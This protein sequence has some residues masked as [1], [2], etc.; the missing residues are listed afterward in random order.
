MTIRVNVDTA[1][2]SS[3]LKDLG[4]QVSDVLRPAAQAGAQVI[5]NQVKLNVG[6]IGKNTGS[7]SDAIYQAFD[8]VASTKQF[9]A[10]GISWNAKKAPHAHLVEYGH[11]Q[12]YQSR[13]GKDG[14]WYTMV[15]PSMRGKP[16]PKGRASQSEKD[17]Y[18]VMRKGGSVQVAAQPFM[19]P[20]LDK[21]P[22][23]AKAIEDELMKRLGLK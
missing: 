5:Y 20:A 18:Y 10:Y 6:R 11:V 12:R 9:A 3:M 16:A 2:L 23:A 21:M 17:A 13:V 22:L 14:K 8:S 15:R 4:D 1:A 7:L 19:R